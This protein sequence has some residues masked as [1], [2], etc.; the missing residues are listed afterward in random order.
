MTALTATAGVLD[1][2]T[3]AADAD[4]ILLVGGADDDATQYLYG[5]NN[6]STATIIADEV[7]LSSYYYNRYNGW[8]SR[9]ST[10]NFSFAITGQ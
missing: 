2:I 1:A 4:A 3:I 8:Y 5:L 10:N 9:L 7:A 6:D